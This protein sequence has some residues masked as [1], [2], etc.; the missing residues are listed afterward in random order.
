MNKNI[1]QARSN[2]KGNK[3]LSIKK[4]EFNIKKMTLNDSVGTRATKKIFKAHVNQSSSPASSGD[5]FIHNEETVKGKIFPRAK[6]M[7][8]TAID[9]KNMDLAHI[10]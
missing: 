1:S 4:L 2:Q 6:N 9:T 7:D 8:R 10:T 3:K 5:E